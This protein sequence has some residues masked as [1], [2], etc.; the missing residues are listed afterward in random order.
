VI[1][2]VI[3]GR[4]ARDRVVHAILGKLDGRSGR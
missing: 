2:P 4:L 3:D 1:N